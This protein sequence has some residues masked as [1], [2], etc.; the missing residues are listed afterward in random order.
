MRVV[1]SPSETMIGRLASLHHALPAPLVIAQ[2]RAEQ[3]RSRYPFWLAEIRWTDAPTDVPE[4]SLV[5][6]R[7]NASAVEV[8]ERVSTGQSRRSGLSEPAST[9]GTAEATAHWTAEQTERT[10]ALSESAATFGC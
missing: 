3:L 5:V 6:R 1:T 8:G 10:C 2:P 7:R 9:L 4:P